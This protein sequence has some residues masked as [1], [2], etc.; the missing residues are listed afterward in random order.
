M[1]LPKNVY[2]LFAVTQA[3]QKMK[4]V[5]ISMSYGK[6]D[7]IQATYMKYLVNSQQGSGENLSLQSSTCGFIIVFYIA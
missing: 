1:R 2:S 3:K 4:D 7:F 5:L 6:A